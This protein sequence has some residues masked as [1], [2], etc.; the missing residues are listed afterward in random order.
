MYALFQYAGQVLSSCSLG[1]SAVFL[2][3]GETR[4]VCP[5]AILLRSGDIVIMSGPSRT[6]YHGVPKIVAP[7]ASSPVPS[8]LSQHILL[9]QIQRCDP[10]QEDGPIG[11]V[12]WVCGRERHS[13]GTE[14]RTEGESCTNCDK[15][16]SQ[17]PDFEN[18]LSISRIN[19]NI[20]QVN[21]SL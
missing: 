15:L 10:T 13:S 17:W 6:F 14:D 8:A 11:S 7:S 18:Y 21:S 9:D 3:G 2:I 4:S 5:H 12:C 1:Q 16:A 20:R 19:V